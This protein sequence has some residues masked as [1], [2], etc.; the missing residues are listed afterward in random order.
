MKFFNT[1]AGFA[2]IDQETYRCEL[3]VIIHSHC[4]LPDLKGLLGKGSTGPP[5][6]QEG[7]LLA[8]SDMP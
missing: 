8:Y 4:S 6:G 5:R 2:N 1:L 7:A 3:I